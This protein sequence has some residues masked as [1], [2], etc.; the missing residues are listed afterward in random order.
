MKI[1][2]ITGASAG[3]GQAFFRSVVK[4]YPELNEIWLIARRADRLEKLGEN[5]PV[6]V[7]PL[8]LDLTD[9]A[10]FT[11]LADRLAGQR[12][13]VQILINNA[14]VG[15]LSDIADSDWLTQTRMVDLNCRALT[16]V[17]TVVLPYMAAGDFIVN[18]ASI[19]AF[20]PTARMTVYSSTKAYVLSMSR[21]LR[22]ELK[23]RGI[24]V[25]A[26][27]P[28]PM[29]TEFLDVAGITGK[30]PTF[31]RLPYCDAE[32]V[33]D[34]AVA[35]AAKGR[36]VITPRFFFKFYRLVAKLLPHDLVMKWCKT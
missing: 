15:E 19:A 25:L 26:V 32:R 34:A 14:G 27:C 4:R 12:P 20:A 30:S 8:A 3:L 31:D 29:R 28:G 23:P 21:G 9:T 10:S 24:H 33:A 6:P 13:Q 17:T 11:A 36:G 1:A 16:A 7:V 35:C 5:S 2:I 18:V 22:E